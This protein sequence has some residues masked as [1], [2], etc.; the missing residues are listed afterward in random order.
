MF[1]A[2]AQWFLKATPPKMYIVGTLKNVKYT[3]V[4]EVAFRVTYFRRRKMKLG[5]H[6]SLQK[7]TH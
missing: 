4:L 7:L 1:E 6:H 2:K 5:M 3:F